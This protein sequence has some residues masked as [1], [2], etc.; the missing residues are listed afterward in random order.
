MGAAGRAFA[1]KEYTVEGQ[2]DRLASEIRS[3][4]TIV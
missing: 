4:T 3:L 2:A 1:E